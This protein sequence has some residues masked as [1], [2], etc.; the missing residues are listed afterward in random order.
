MHRRLLLVVIAPL[1]ACA[2]PV[3]APSTA[4]APAAVGA[5]AALPPVPLVDGPLAV[6][7]VYPRPDQ[8]L[9]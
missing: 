1:L 9:T 6:R 3:F 8:V 5:R 2:R 7:V 4:P